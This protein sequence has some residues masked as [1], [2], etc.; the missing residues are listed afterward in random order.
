VLQHKKAHLRIYNHV[1][2][3]FRR[4]GGALVP[5]ASEQAVIGR[6]KLHRANG[7]TLEKIAATL[8]AEG[9]PTKKVGGK[10][11][12]RTIL[13]LLENPLHQAA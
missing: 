9:V 12:A 8:N 2:Y 5:D 7:G 11:Y 6:V 1:P 10:W 13:N 4:A 3:G